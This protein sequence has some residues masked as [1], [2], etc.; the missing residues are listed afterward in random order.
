ME[1]S[2]ISQCGICEKGDLSL[3]WD[4]PNFPLTEKYGT[5]DPQKN[6]HFDQQLLICETCG[7]VQLSAQISPLLL[8]TPSEY[9]FRT[10]QSSSARRGAEI[11]FSF[12]E[13]VKGKKSFH[14]LLDVGG[15]DLF[16]AKMAPLKERCVVDPV[17]SEEDGKIVDGIKIIGTFLEK[18]DFQKEGLFPD[19]IFCRHVLEHIP[20]PKEFIQ[21]LFQ[22]CAPEALYIFEVPCFENLREANRFD[23][24]FHQHYH[25]FD[26]MTFQR[27]IAETGGKYL[28]HHHYRQGPCGGSL[29]IA[30]C[31]EDSL[32]SKVFSLNIRE[33]KKEIADAIQRYQLQM[34]LLS[35]QL[36]RFQKNIYGY[37]ASL[38]LATLAYH[39]KTD[40]SELLCIFDDDEE[41]DQ[42]GYQN[43]PVS[44]RCTKFCQIESNSNFFI[45]SLENTRAIF[46]RITEFS[47]RRILVPC[48]S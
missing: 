35:H 30:F 24:I 5:Y 37:G 38:M 25:Y 32:S 4:L 40:F 27:L 39:L 20:R 8:Y 43:I 17:C 45:T 33:R 26:L 48:I 23:A 13:Q 46:K 19:L 3:L 41:K 21:R 22:A 18:V 34:D 15:N 12:Y 44:V 6:L 10:G 16:L 9:S 2:L 42:I 7:H 11:F 28:A 29:L 31:K 36:K 1:K 47:P 14:S